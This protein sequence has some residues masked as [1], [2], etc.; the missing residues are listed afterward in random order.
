[1]CHGKLAFMPN[2]ALILYLITL[3][4]KPRFNCGGQIKKIK[5]IL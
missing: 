4:L 2:R 1:M 5:V 3:C